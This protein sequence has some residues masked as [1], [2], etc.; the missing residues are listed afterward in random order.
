M[1]W[2]A[3]LYALVSEQVMRGIRE[4]FICSYL[5]PSTGGLDN[6]Y[7]S[8][9]G[10]QHGNTLCGKR[11]TTTRVLDSLQGHFSGTKK[12][13][14]G[15]RALGLGK[16]EAAISLRIMCGVLVEAKP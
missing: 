15:R 7:L 10:G 16:I 1:R 3:T 12:G 5:R 14:P 11:L 9:A 6:S 4:H 8:S 2:L 13:H